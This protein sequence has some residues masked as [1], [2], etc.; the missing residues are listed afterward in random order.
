MLIRVDNVRKVITEGREASVALLIVVVE[1][2]EGR[3][4][5]LSLRFERKGAFNGGLI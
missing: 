4:L 1:V 2:F 3:F 5:W